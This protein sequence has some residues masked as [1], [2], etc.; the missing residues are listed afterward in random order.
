MLE[1]SA[2]LPVYGAVI[3]IVEPILCSGKRMMWE[4][5]VGEGIEG[6]GS[7]PRES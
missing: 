5:A 1:K 2:D 4:V 7:S 3:D 6:V